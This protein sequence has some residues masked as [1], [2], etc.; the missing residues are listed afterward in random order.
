M[1]CGRGVQAGSFGFKL[2]FA[3][4]NGFSGLVAEGDFHAVNQVDSG[5][6]GGS[7]AQDGHQRIWNEAH[8]HQV[9]LD[10]FREVKG[11]EDA[12]CTD[13]QLT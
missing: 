1:H 12:T 7:A 10:G 9:V 2:W 11:D 13:L 3:D 5:I 8:V 4:A 6:A